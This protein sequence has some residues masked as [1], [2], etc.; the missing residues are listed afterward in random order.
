MIELNDNTAKGDL[1]I[2]RILNEQSFFSN[3]NNLP[4]KKKKPESWQVLKSP[5]RFNRVFEFNNYNFLKRFISYVLEYQSMA[6]HHGEINIIG[7]NQV[8]I[9]VYTH[10]VNDI[11]NLD[12]E[13]IDQVSGIYD[14]LE[15][16]LV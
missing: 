3:T 14:D 7:N 6:K 5:N 9:S 10:D 8:E 13:Y 2:N 16:M 1:R 12:K 11:T 4:V 15:H